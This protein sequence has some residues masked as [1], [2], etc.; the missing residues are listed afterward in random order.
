MTDMFVLRRPHDEQREW[1]FRME[2][3][4]C[5]WRDNDASQAI[6]EKIEGL[7]RE[8]A[9]SPDFDCYDVLTLK[10]IVKDQLEKMID[11]TVERVVKDK[12]IEYDDTD[13][14]PHATR[15]IHDVIFWG[16]GTR[17]GL[18]GEIVVSRLSKAIGYCPCQQDL[19]AIPWDSEEQAVEG[20][21][22]MDEIDRKNGEA[23]LRCLCD[24]SNSVFGMDVQLVPSEAA[25][26]YHQDRYEEYI[27]SACPYHPGIEDFLEHNDNC[28]CGLDGGN[29]PVRWHRADCKVIREGA[30]LEQCVEQLRESHGSEAATKF[31]VKYANIMAER[32]PVPPRP[33]VVEDTGAAQSKSDW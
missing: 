27:C 33:A 9:E 22:Y 30:T 15:R 17:S 13:L 18:E 5:P 31:A 16:N 11:K 6:G 8:M 4:I 26:Q 28:W 29:T 21:K 23:A 19:A 24:F 20:H 14:T 2:Q 25:R 1:E 32:G 3:V 7:I 10:M 12:G